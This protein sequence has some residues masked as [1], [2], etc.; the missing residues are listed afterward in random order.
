MINIRKKNNLGL[1]FT[2]H[3]AKTAKDVIK[4]VNNI[5]GID[6]P[7]APTDQV[8][9][10]FG[11]QFILSLSWIFS[12]FISK[13]FIY[14]P[15]VTKK[16]IKA[17]TKANHLISLPSPLSGKKGIKN[18]LPIGNRIDTDNQGKSDK[19]IPNVPNEWETKF[20]KK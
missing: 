2:G 14:E 13:P 15:T 18:A 4:L 1:N 5:S 10:S 9:P 6:I 20:V 19:P 3:A 17:T 16:V 7:S 11:S 12:L 8:K